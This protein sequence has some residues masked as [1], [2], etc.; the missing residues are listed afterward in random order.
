MGYF[1]Y[2]GMCWEKNPAKYGS[3]SQFLL[4]PSFRRRRKVQKVRR[5]KE[6]SECILKNGSHKNFGGK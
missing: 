1:N 5:K 4:A 6:N 3:S 2:L